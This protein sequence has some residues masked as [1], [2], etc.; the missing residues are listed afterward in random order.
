M[1]DNAAQSSLRPPL[2]KAWVSTVDL[3]VAVAGD[4][5]IYGVTDTGKVVSV[6]PD[7]GA[8]RWSTTTV[9]LRGY[10]TV[11]G[12]KLY[13]Y[14]QNEG[15]VVISDDGFSFTETL[16]IAINPLV[17]GTPVSNILAQAGR[18]Y[19]TTN[20]VL[21][22]I[23]EAG[24][25]VASTDIG[26][27]YPHTLV[28]VGP[29]QCVAV[30]GYGQ[31][32]FYEVHGSNLRR[33]YY[34][35]LP[36]PGTTQSRRP[37]L[38]A[39]GVMLTG[40]NGQTAAY[41]LSGGRILWT[42]PQFA[43]QAFTIAKGVAYAATAAG[44]VW[45]FSPA[46]GRVLWRRM[47]M[48]PTTQTSQVGI[49]ESNGYLYVGVFIAD[50]G[51]IYLFALRSDTGEFVWQ[52]NSAVLA[53]GVGLPFFYGQLLIPYGTGQPA[54]SM[55]AV[56]NPRVTAER[57]SWT[58]NPLTGTRSDFAGRLTLD[59]PGPV[60]ATITAMGE[61]TG[62]GQRLMNHSSLNAG[63]HTFEWNAG[64][65][66]GFSDANQ[67]ARMVVDVQ[68]TG[69]VNY[70]V[71]KLIPINTLPDLLGH[72]AR[73]NIEIMLYH[74][75]VGGY[76]DLTFRADNLVTRAES[77]TIIAKTLDLSR[78]SPQFHTQFTDISNHWARA[79]ITALEERGI[80]GGFRENDGT[81]TFRPELNMTRAQEARIVLKA[82][83]V[84][85]APAGFRT[86]FTDIAGHWA[87]HD[88]EALENAGYVSGYQEA[89]GTF[90]YR[91]EQNLSRAE[92]STMVVRVRRLGR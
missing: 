77:C 34:T 72:W 23:T 70:T 92:L 84:S 5:T 38:I 64:E 49:A 79:F 76:P 42:S 21:L 17:D 3:R 90:T 83:S 78:P 57:V 52:S 87:Q 55:G 41:D 2:Q 32:M 27:Q 81:L 11:A 69:G 82:Y 36:N 61:T 14:K 44:H 12:T 39:G 7:T 65:P 4:N 89:D 43:A 67:F 68:E 15:L 80:I 45:A 10:L 24:G 46:D 6:N 9:H 91:P 26:N 22:V 1:F 28:A 40:A 85:P 51:P 20:Q 71:T 88:I 66:N 58:P 30:D 29:N 35:M 54:V 62:L 86:K 47:Y 59:L 50:G 8:V 56:D 73:A 60:T 18:I 75:Y 13:C 48:Y 31:P 63:T 33:L 37:V 74:R 53:H 16:L 19:F 25:L